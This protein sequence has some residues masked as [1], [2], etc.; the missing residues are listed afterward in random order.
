MKTSK[1]TTIRSRL[2]TSYALVTL[3]T[4]VAI[5]VATLLISY[6]AGRQQ[7]VER[8][9]SVAAR[10]ESAILDWT[11]SLERE[12][13]V[14]AN[15]EGTAERIGVLLELARDGRQYLYY[16]G[17]VLNRLRGLVRQSSLLSGIFLL[18]EDGTVVLSTDPDEVGRTFADEPFFQR[19]LLAPTTQLPFNTEGR[20]GPPTVVSALPV[21]GPDGNV[22]GVIAGRADVAKLI[23]AMGDRTGL[24][25]SGRSYIMDQD[26]A[27][28]AGMTLGSADVESAGPTPATLG[29]QGSDA[30][31]RRGGVIS[32]TFRDHRGTQV[33]GVYRWLPDLQ[34][35]L[36]T[37]Q[38]LAR[39]VPS[40]CADAVDERG[41]CAGSAALLRARGARD[42]AQHRPA[43]GQPRAN[44]DRDRQWRPDA[45][46][47]GRPLG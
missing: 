45:D 16:N 8:L 38:D 23:A 15:I 21:L 17:A 28:L 34:V 4:A 19:G 43:A 47:L 32:G 10:K 3:V 31:I 9:E 33:L 11:H 12:L 7:A 42:G 24:G 18:D 37:E 40:R 6:F 2:F 13:V 22:A 14:A 36:A 35:L 46:R 26:R 27:L 5:G 29:G 41:D 30:A 1:P 44:R 20:P 25:D 39:G